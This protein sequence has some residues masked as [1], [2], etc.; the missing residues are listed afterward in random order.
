VVVTTMQV[1]D[2][3]PI[4]LGEWGVHRVYGYPNDGINGLLGA[5]GGADGDPEFTSPARRSRPSRRA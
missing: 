4:R 2:F 3:V 1:A 5:F